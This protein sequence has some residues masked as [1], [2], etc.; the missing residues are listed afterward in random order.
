MDET[1]RQILKKTL[2]EREGE[3]LSYLSELVSID[4]QDLGHG[5]DGG[6]E[7][8]GQIFLENLMRGFGADTRREPLSE[9]II[10]EG[11][12]LHGEGNPGHNYVN[13]DRWNLA[14]FFERNAAGRSIMFDGHIDTMP[15]GDPSQWSL[16][17]WRPEVRDGRLYGLG[18]CDMKAGLMASVL[19]VKLIYDAGLRPPGPV[20]ILSV[21]DEEGGGNGSLAAMLSGHRADAAVVCEPSGGTLTVAHMGFI[22]FSVEVTG[23]ALHSGGKWKGVNAIEKAI[24][25]IEALNELERVW[26]MTHKHP[27]LPPPTLNIGV[28]SGGVAGS[29]VPDKCVFKLCL[30]YHPATMSH[31][32]AARDVREAV[33]T[34][35]QG[36]AWLRDHPPKLEIYQSGGAFE[37]DVGHPFVSAASDCISAVK[38]TP[39]ELFGSPAGNDARLLRNIGGMPTVVAGPGR[40]EQCHGVD[41]YVEVADFLDFLEIYALLILE[42]CGGL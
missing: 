13:P 38:G 9:E 31:E 34:R 21:V 11:I 18:A 12:A 22:F 37:M 29:T 32:S 35:A 36:D 17:P 10:S 26:L 33:R 19:A 14:A 2:R 24:L 6:M 3:Y 23:V 1:T 27:L 42:W 5:I 7:E 28:I 16:D 30:H 15:P 20:T 40:M 25:L 8:K 39:P 41:E 4:T